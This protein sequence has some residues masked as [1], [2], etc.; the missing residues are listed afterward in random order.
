VRILALESQLDEVLLAGP[1]ASKAGLSRAY[2]EEMAK[3]QPLTR[4]AFERYVLLMN[5]IPGVSVTPG[6]LAGDRAG[7][8]K[9]LLD[10][11][12]QQVEGSFAVDSRG[13][14]RLGRVQAQGSLQLNGLG[15]ESSQTRL[16]AAASTDLESF[17]SAGL[18]HAGT[19]TPMAITGSVSLG[20][21]RTRPQDTAIEGEGYTAGVQ[22]SHPLI[23]GSVT[24]VYIAGGIDGVNNENALVGQLETSDRTRAA[25]AAV[26]ASWQKGPTALS[27]SGSLSQ[28]IDGLG[29]E[30]ADPT[31][32]SVEFFKGNIRAGVTQTLGDRWRLVGAVSAQ[33]SEDTLPAVE[34]MSLGGGQ[35]GRALE[36]GAVSGDS[37]M[38]ASLEL[39]RSIGQIGPVKASEVYG[40]VDGGKLWVNDRPGVTLTD[41]DV[42]SAGVGVRVA[43]S[44]FAS[45]GVEVA[46]AVDVAFDGVDEHDWR[47]TVSLGAVF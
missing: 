27:V 26:T 15:Y 9:I 18:S 23:R 12:Q 33:G 6:V 31:L 20:Y 44:D 11:R 10:R 28:G 21:Y 24:N 14:E 36:T 47:T 43:V 42:A 13:A 32:S 16:T 22:L 40:F 29:A 1:G 41:F 17:L 37:G 8:A 19:F 35:F 46:H 38:A 2:A 45:L 39:T 30:V 25:R 5:D 7:T 4:G 3:K 34:L